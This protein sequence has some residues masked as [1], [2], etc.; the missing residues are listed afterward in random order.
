MPAGTYCGKVRLDGYVTPE[1]AEK[2]CKIHEKMNMTSMAIISKSKIVTLA[3]EEF[4]ENHAHDEE[5][6]EEVA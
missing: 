5:F 3:I 4:I 6:I 2:F 1:I